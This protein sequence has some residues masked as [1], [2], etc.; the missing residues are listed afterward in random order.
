M[1]ALRIIAIAAMI[2]F[3]GTT[4][5][6]AQ[7]LPPGTKVTKLTFTKSIIKDDMPTASFPLGGWNPDDT[8]SKVIPLPRALIAV[9]PDKKEAVAIALIAVTGP[10]TGT[11]MIAESTDSPSVLKK[12]T[13]EIHTETDIVLNQTKYGILELPLKDDTTP[14]TYVVFVACLSTADMALQTRPPDSHYLVSERYIITLPPLEAV[15]K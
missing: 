5:A 13:V 14:H 2:C 4:Q 8:I 6:V 15:L 12:G 9:S 11:C 7:D 3:F 10:T 1:K